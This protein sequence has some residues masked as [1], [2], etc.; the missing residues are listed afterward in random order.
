MGLEKLPPKKSRRKKQ[1]SS[2]DLCENSPRHLI[3]KTQNDENGSLLLV[4]SYVRDRLMITRCSINGLYS[5]CHNYGSRTWA[6][7][8]RKLLLEGLNLHFHD[9]GRQGISVWRNF[10]FSQKEMSGKKTWKSWW[11]CLW[12]LKKQLHLMPICV[13]VPKGQLDLDVF[14]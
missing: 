2:K 1:I 4:P 3:C 13:F 11:T 10:F 14:E 12:K 8:E 9:Y 5:S 7:V 6:L